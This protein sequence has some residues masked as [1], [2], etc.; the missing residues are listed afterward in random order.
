MQYV[1]C[2]SLCWI[3][4]CCITGNS[5]AASRDS[6]ATLHISVTLVSTIAT[7]TTESVEQTQVASSEIRGIVYNLRPDAEQ[8]LA[9]AVISSQPTAQESARTNL[10]NSSKDEPIVEFTTVVMK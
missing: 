8:S 10:K 9:E 3:L 4:L 2:I 5:Y 6:R 7:G 1:R